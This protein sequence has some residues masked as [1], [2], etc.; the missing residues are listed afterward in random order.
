MAAENCL[1]G[2]PRIHGELLKLGITVSERTVSRYLRGRPTTRSQS[3]RT[4][5]ANHLGGPTLISPVMVADAHDENIVVDSDLSF[6]PAPPIDASRASIH[7]SS[8]D[9]GRPLQ[10]SSVGARLGQNHLQYGTAVRRSS[11]RDPPRHLPRCNQ[12]RGVRA[13]FFVCC[14]SAFATDGR[15]RSIGPRV[16]DDFT[17][18]SLNSKNNRAVNVV[19]R[20]TLGSVREVLATFFARRSEYW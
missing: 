4:F 13:G 16:L 15:V 7:R 9:W 12:P 5:F 2:A 6:R 1:W 8:V 17:V 14:D 3:W 11:G 10:P 19:A 20:P 18:L